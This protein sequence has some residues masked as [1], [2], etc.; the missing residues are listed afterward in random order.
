M[1]ENLGLLRRRLAEV[2][3]L[4]MA[5]AVLGWDQRT[6]MPARGA[7]ARARQK[8]TLARLAHELHVAPATRDA[9]AGAALETAQL[10]ADHDD[11]AFV[12]QAT[13]DFEK[14]VRLPESLVV[15]LA[16]T[17]SLAEEQ[18]VV[19]RSGSDYSRFAPWLARLLD[20][21]RQY[22]AAVAP[23]V[24]IY[25]ALMDDYEP[26]CTTAAID[27]LFAALKAQTVPLL[28]SI[29]E[30]G[31]AVSDDPLRRH[32]EPEDQR[33]FIARI[34]QDCGFDF[35][36]G[37]LDPTVHP[38]CTS[39]SPNDVRITTRYDADW[40]P[41]SLFGCLHEMGHAFYEMNVDPAYEATPLAG[42]VSL[43]V[44]ES[45][46]RLWEN[47]VGRSLGFWTHYYPALQKA[48]P[49]LHDVPLADFHRA[50]NKVGRSLIRVEADE[51]TYN[52]HIILRYEMEVALLTG[53]L[54]VADAPAA[55]NDKMKTLLSLTP[56]DDRNGILQDVHWS[57]G[58][59][60]YFPTYT[61]GNILSVQIYEAAVAAHPMIPTDLAAGKFDHLFHWLKE[62]IHRPGK[63]YLPGDLITRAT[64]R[65]LTTEPYMN[66]L[67]NKVSEI[68]GL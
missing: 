47:L 10:P 68:Y 17:E 58:A 67:K 56:P 59:F 33:R 21:K 15:A 19:A 55:W 61:L 20:L 48:S 29:A 25:D 51:V 53:H 5:N 57:H 46:S 23:G 49:A 36:R 43:G 42:G 8:A 52:L 66:Y 1:T 62:N 4:N 31:R 16:E 50:I 45:Q 12:R 24:P 65:P 14:V 27:P 2:D 35:Q 26:G 60:G 28:A 6:Y 63:K 30:R 3:N 41:G 18:W 37:R 11:A 13:R 32:F 7:E 34:I 64:G 40:L 9:L 44:H 39:F 54:S 38:F 22:A